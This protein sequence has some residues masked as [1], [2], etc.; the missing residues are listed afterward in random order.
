MGR[1]GP[2]WDA[3]AD[4]ADAAN[5]AGAAEVP[6]SR[7]RPAPKPSSSRVQPG[8]AALWRR[9]AAWLIDEVARTLFYPLILLVFVLL[10]GSPPATV[11]PTEVTLADVL[12]QIVLRAGL[13]WLFW[14]R[15]TSPGAMVLHV[16]LVDAEGLPPG[17]RRAAIRALVEIVS[18][19][20]LFIG[21]AWALFSRR[22]QTWHDMASGVYVVDAPAENDPTGER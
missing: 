6:E 13:S 14:S 2:R 9:V 15:G 20:T 22:R 11:S 16:R 8:D 19:S 10:G 5:V 17:G 3:G 12:P 18:V 21:F 4:V 7:P 1:P